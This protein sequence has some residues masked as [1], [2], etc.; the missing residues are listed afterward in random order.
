MTMATVLAVLLFV[1]VETIA[2]IGQMSEIVVCKH[3][4][5]RCNMICSVSWFVLISSM[6]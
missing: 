3:H 6:L 5:L 4:S 1:T 2:G